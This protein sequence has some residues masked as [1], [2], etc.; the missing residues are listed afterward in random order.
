MA[1]YTKRNAVSGL[2]AASLEEAAAAV[3]LWRRR[4]VVEP[5]S[6]L[7]GWNSQ[8]SQSQRER[9]RLGALGLSK[10]E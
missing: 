7:A 5:K 8:S 1:A 4:Q 2:L 6:L 3:A 9:D 10:G